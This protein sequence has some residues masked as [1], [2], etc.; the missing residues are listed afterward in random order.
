MA[1]S[2]SLTR[3]YQLPSDDDKVYVVIVDGKAVYVSTDKDEA[4]K[5]YEKR[6]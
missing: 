4:T 1:L 3:L 2:R 6:K 5:E